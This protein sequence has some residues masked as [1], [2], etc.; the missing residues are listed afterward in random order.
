MILGS[1]CTPFLKDE[2]F[3]C[4]GPQ[5]SIPR[6]YNFYEMIA[7]LCQGR[8]FFY[9]KRSKMKKSF[10]LSSWRGVAS[11]GSI[12]LFFAACG[13]EVTTQVIQVS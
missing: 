7:A 12:A 8:S 6:L 13:D 11:I 10:R 9:K 5:H 1:C 4:E 3:V 2:P